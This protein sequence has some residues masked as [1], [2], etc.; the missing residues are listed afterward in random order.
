MSLDLVIL[1]DFNVISSD[2][3]AV[4]CYFVKF[5][6]LLVEKWLYKRFKCFRILMNFFMK[7]GGGDGALMHVYV[8]EHIVSQYYRTAE[9]MFIVGMK[10]S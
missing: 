2:V 6:F 7:E 5:L 4:K 3:N 10:C 8:W 1:P 9:W